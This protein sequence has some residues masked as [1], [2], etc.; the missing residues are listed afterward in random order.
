MKRG[1][2][3]KPELF[4]STTVFFCDIVGFTQIASESTAHQIIGKL[5]KYSDVQ[6]FIWKGGKKKGFKGVSWLI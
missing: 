2:M 1:V 3:P 6:V 5:F 4:T